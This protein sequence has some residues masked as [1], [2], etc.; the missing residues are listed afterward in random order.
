MFTCLRPGVLTFEV[1]FAASVLSRPSAL[2]PLQGGPLLTLGVAGVVPVETGA[3][4]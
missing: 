2:L 4:K 1:I 3:P